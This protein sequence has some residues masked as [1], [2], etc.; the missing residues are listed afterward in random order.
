MSKGVAIPD[1]YTLDGHRLPS[2]GIY[3][4]QPGDCSLPCDEDLH[5]L[6]GA[7]PAL[8]VV[9]ESGGTVLGWQSQADDNLEQQLDAL[10]KGQC[11]LP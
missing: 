11:L 6:L 7:S 8:P 5:F 9:S 4:R 10:Q 1:I 3:S 2:D